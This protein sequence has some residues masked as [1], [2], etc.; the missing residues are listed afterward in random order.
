MNMKKFLSLLLLS[1]FSL[2]CFAQAET[3]EKT[4]KFDFTDGST[5]NPAI[6]IPEGRSSIDVIDYVFTAGPIS[7]SFTANKL[8]PAYK[9]YNGE[10]KLY[11][12]GGNSIIIK[13]DNEHDIIKFRFSDGTIIGGFGLPRENAVGTLSSSGEW[14]NIDKEGNEIDGIKQLVLYNSQSD[15]KITGIEVTY[16]SPLDV[17][18]EPTCTPAKDEVVNS[19]DK[20]VFTFDQEIASAEK[21]LTIMTSGKE[22]AAVLKNPVVKGKTVTYTLAEAITKPD[23]Y[24]V[25]VPKRA[26][27]AVEGYYNKEF[28]TSFVVKKPLNVFDPETVPGGEAEIF[29]DTIDVTFPGNIGNIAKQELDIMSERNGKVGIVKV[30]KKENTFNTMQLVYEGSDITA[31]DIYTVTVPA[32]TVFDVNYGS[33]ETESTYNNEFVIEYKVA[34]ADAP[35]DSILAVAKAFLDKTGVGYPVADAPSRLKLADMVDKVEEGDSAFQAAIDAFVAT[36]SIEFPSASKYYTIANVS[37]NGTKRFLAYN[38]GKVTLTTEESE[39]YSFQPVME[40]SAAVSNT[41]N[42]TEPVKKSMYFKTLDGKYLHT[43]TAQDGIYSGVSSANVTSEQ[44]DVNLLTLEKMTSENPEET[45]GYIAISGLI[46]KKY[47][48]GDD[49]VAYSNVLSS[50]TIADG[51]TNAYFINTLSGAFVFAEAEAPKVDVKYEITVYPE[52]EEDHIEALESVVV[53]F[54][55][56]ENVVLGD[57]SLFY[58]DPASEGR[59]NIAATSAEVLGDKK[60]AVKVLFPAGLMNDDYTFVAEEGAFTFTVYEQNVVAEKMEKTFKVYIPDEFIRDFAISPNSVLNNNNWSNDVYSP[61][62]LNRLSIRVINKN[63]KGVETFV[64]DKDVELLLGGTKFIT[65]GKFVREVIEDRY[66]EK[67]FYRDGEKMGIV[68]YHSDM[69]MTYYWYDENYTIHHGKVTDFGLGHNDEIR[70]EVRYEYNYNLNLK[71]AEEID[72][73]TCDD[74]IYWF[75]IYEDTFGDSN[76]GKYLDDPA[77]IA[78]KQCHT[79]NKFIMILEVSKTVGISG[80]EN[81]ENGEEVIYDLS[82]RRMKST[83][84]PGIYIKNGKKVVVR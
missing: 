69:T 23:T 35:S 80:I 43:L 1:I 26:F 55:E 75:V 9:E 65:T 42:A 66:E 5:L 64:S 72:P 32:E 18:A 41:E 68:D 2:G 49:I 53:T 59:E 82:G 38:D 47:G 62:E 57:K 25:S 3:K 70:D 40:A 81:I 44:K 77:S 31:K 19:L 61:T 30:S 33:T 79:N 17:L 27:T 11:M 45:F 34:G 78:K 54:P 74:G 15:S 21:E 4:V 14:V 39:A 16:R 24:T 48:A 67:I 20:F 50:G 36:D 7:L 8:Y 60:N 63:R 10:K 58:L 13:S 37:V 83:S 22:P 46:G 12:Y 71:L 28:S 84:Q 52:T 51:E 6:E 29:P 73:E 56:L 76:F